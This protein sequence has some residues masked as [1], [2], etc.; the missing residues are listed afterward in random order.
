VLKIDIERVS[1]LKIRLIFKIILRSLSQFLR[2]KPLL[3][4]ILVS[5]VICLLHS[6]RYAVPSMFEG[7]ICRQPAVDSS[8]GGVSDSEIQ[9]C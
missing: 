8:H 2:R 3:V 5:S 1:K 9:F 6:Y 7:Q 4:L